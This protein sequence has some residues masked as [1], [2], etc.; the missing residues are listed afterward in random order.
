[1][2]SII[3]NNYNYGRFLGAAIESALSQTYTDTEVVVVDD[4]SDDESRAI[5]E[6]YGAQ[7][8]AV[9]KDNGG[10]AS[11][12]NAGF[13]RCRG[14][15]VI[16]LD[17][18][19]VV[20]PDIGARVVATYAAQPNCGKVEYRMYVIDA[21]GRPT[22]GLKPAE[23]LAR[24]SGDL[25]RMELRS[26]F[27]ILWMSTSANAFSRRV[28]G[29]ILPVPEK[30]YPVCGAD[31]YLAHVSPFFGPVVFLDAIGASY[32][33][34]GSNHF[35][36]ERLDLQQIH[37]SI[38]FM[39]TTLG[40]IEQTARR[41]GLMDPV[42]GPRQILSF[43]YVAQRM[44]LHKL[45]SPQ[46]PSEVEQRGSLLRLGVTALARR[47]DIS[48]SLKVAMCLWLVCLAAAPY[49]LAWTL[50]EQFMLPERRPAWVTSALRAAHRPLQSD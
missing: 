40:C 22:G 39:R 13:E 41:V 21:A 49:P 20:L 7:V 29:E 50:A 1:L 27:E 18:D 44:I 46:H 16:F 10:Q 3:I 36:S 9:F 11:A 47:D 26:P 30:G 4:G 45:A 25:R 23:Y 37:E 33:V 14:D 48:V 31:W 17:A 43:T 6:R 2:L 32:R 5:I 19:D 35:S 12:L 34:H 8:V 28:L 42:A 24:P 38:V 15:I